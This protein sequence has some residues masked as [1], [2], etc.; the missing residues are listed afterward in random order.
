MYHQVRYDAGRNDVAARHRLDRECAIS[1]SAVSIKSY[2]YSRL[3]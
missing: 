1:E 3:I 2:I